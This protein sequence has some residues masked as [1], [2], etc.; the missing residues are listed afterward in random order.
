MLKQSLQQKLLQKLSPQQIQLM[1]LIQLPTIALE[2]RIEKEL[3]ENPVLDE[4]KELDNLNDEFEENDSETIDTEDID[5]DAYLSDDEIPDY[6]LR[7]QN[8]S[9]EDKAMNLP[10]SV[11]ESFLQVLKKQLSLQNIGNHKQEI[12]EYIIG[13]IDED[14]YLRRSLEDILDDLA[15]HQNIITS[16]NELEELLQ[17]IQQLDPSGV[18]AR[19]LQECLLLQLKR[20]KGTPPIELAIKIITDNFNQFIKKH[21]SKIIQKLDVNKEELKNAI[22]E[23]EKL[24]P[25][26]GGNSIQNKVAEQIIPDFSIKIKDTE[27]ELTLNSKNAPELHIN[28]SYKEMLDTFSSNKNNATKQEKE[29]I[30]FIKQKMDSARW[31]IDAIKQRQNTLITTMQAIMTLQEEYFLTGDEQKIKPMILKDIAEKINMDISTISR[32]A[33]NKYVSTPYGTIL[34]KTLFSESMKNE[35]GD[36]VSTKEIKNILLEVIKSEE[37][38]KPL[39]DDKLA[40][41]LKEKGYPI[42]RRTIAKYREQLGLP[43]ARLRKQL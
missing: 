2:Q 40:K 35:Q 5:I 16:L 15:F 29:S 24:N 1:K 38:Q 8:Q 36:D 26:P 14:G 39:T 13:N 3:E 30:L 10:L 6:K 43:V 18:A 41:L 21:Y 4:G 19:N 32:V 9:A 42:A 17:I 33:S 7:A 22:L 12:A 31:F 27:L 28:N 20:K 34:I 11:S 23:I 37:K 25:K